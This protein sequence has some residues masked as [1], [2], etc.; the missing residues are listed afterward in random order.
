MTFKEFPAASQ[1]A[2]QSATEKEVVMALIAQNDQWAVELSV[3][4]V[5]DSADDSYSGDIEFE[6]DSL[7]TFLEYASANDDEWNSTP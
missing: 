4:Q 3:Q 6:S 2:R 1:Y 5:I 7:S